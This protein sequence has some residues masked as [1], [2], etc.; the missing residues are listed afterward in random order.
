V[1]G[2]STAYHQDTDSCAIFI[3]DGYPGGA[4]I[5]E[6]GF[7][8]GER[9]LRATLDAVRACPCQRGCPSCVQSPKCG[10]GNEP[11]DK[12]GGARLL[13]AILG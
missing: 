4:G 8:S 5:C 11:L 10:N 3:Y 2:V 13:E 6:R 9:L 1:G 7:R 12:E